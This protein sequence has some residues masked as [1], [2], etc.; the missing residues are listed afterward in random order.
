MNKYLMLFSF[1]FV[2]GSVFAED[3]KT[4][5]GEEYKN[6]T[7]SRAEPDGIVVIMTSG[8]VKLYFAEL[9]KEVREKYHYDAE[10]AAAFSATKAEQ[11]QAIYDAARS[12]KAEQ[13]QKQNE[14]WITH[15]AAVDP[16]AQG[17]SL[18]Q[19]YHVIGRV[20]EK[21]RNGKLIVQ[22]TGDRASPQSPQGRVLLRGHP[23]SVMLA[24][25]DQVDLNGTAVGTIEYKS[26]TIHVYQCSR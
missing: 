1:V 2:A 7:V 10:K 12:A 8:I 26:K 15:P 17:G 18:D 16:A 3:F 13:A 19:K 14:Y 21:L 20:V 23:N 11:Q 22:C 4:L 9:P 6:V 5:D 24:P 25:N